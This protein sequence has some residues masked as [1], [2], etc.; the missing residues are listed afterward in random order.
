MQAFN[1]IAGGLAFT[2]LFASFADV[3]IY[4]KPETILLTVGFSL[5]PDIDHTKSI[6]GKAVYPLASWLMKNYGHR[7]VTHSI[8]FWLGCVLCVGVI[9]AVFDKSWTLICALS[10]GSHLIFDMCTRQGI[11]I[12]Y[13]FSKRP[14]VL[15]A[16]PRLRL[17]GGDLRSEAVVFIMFLALNMFGFDLMAAGFWTK[18]NRKFMTFD[19][20]EREIRRKPADYKIKYSTDSDTSEAI[21]QELKGSKLVLWKDKFEVI[22]VEK[23]KLIDFEKLPTKRVA[24]V[25]NMFNVSIDS[26]NNFISQ[27]RILSVTVQS[28]T[29]IYYF[30]GTIMKKNSEFELKYCSPRFYELVRDNRE[31]EMRLKML[32]LQER[33]EL[34][35]YQFELDYENDVR[36]ELKELDSKTE[37]SNYLEGQRRNRHKLLESEISHFRKHFKPS[38]EHYDVEKSMLKMKLSGENRINATLLFWE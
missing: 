32:G 18:Y 5:L 36:S 13:P 37:N 20:L 3:N 29:E 38:R 30:D 23:L 21:V 10:L 14:A 19:H 27:K 26:L 31:T 9:D 12:F 8:F 28:S 11:P 17:Q 7:T 33:D 24:K 15:P 34:A 35:K 6:V 22:D 16:N 1:H 4:D 2:G 25:L